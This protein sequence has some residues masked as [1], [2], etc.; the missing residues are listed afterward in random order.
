MIKRHKFKIIF[1]SP[2]FFL[3][4]WGIPAKVSAVDFFFKTP[5][6]AAVGDEITVSAMVGLDVP[7]NAIQCSIGFD[8]NSLEF[9]SYQDSKSIMPL[10]ID[11]PALNNDGKLFF[12]GLIPGG[13]GP[14]SSQDDELVSFVFKAKSAGTTRLEYQKC[15]VYTNGPAGQEAQV[16]YKVG[17]FSV[18]SASAGGGRKAVI[19]D[20]YPPEPF[21]IYLVKNPLLLDNRYAAVFSAQDKESGISHYE[22]EEKFLG[23]FGGWRNCE[24]PCQLS[25][26]SLFSIIK[27]AAYDNTGRSMTASFIPARMVYLFVAVLCAILAAIIIALVRLLFIVKRKR[28]EK[29]NI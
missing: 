28:F 10:W 12:S 13:I 11:K 5:S 21:E 6:D 3:A 22:I 29:N 1:L 2:I 18:N 24:S 14:T 4:L 7:V 19:S 16:T 9:L 17:S 8:Q 27:V 15:S 26:Q 23:L 25:H 20:S